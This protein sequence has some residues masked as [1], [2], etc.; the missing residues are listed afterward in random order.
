MTVSDHDLLQ[1]AASTFS[2]VWALD[3][4]LLLKRQPRRW[5][6]A[7][8]VTAL[9]ASELVVTR[10]LD[11]LHAAGLVSIEADAAT[12][13]PKNGEVADRVDGVQKLY[14]GRPDTVRRAICS[15]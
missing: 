8:L 15:S 5:R 10:A 11:S 14:V 1:F 6:R 4:L 9:R 2:S 12:Y 3:L 7:E 13:R